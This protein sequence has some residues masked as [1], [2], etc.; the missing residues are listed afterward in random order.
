MST[1]MVAFLLLTK[2]R[3]GTTLEQL[4]MELEWLREVLCHEKGQSLSSQEDCNALVKQAMHYLGKEMIATEKLSMK[5]STWSR[6]PANSAVPV[7]AT[8]GRMKN[9][10]SNGKTWQD[11]NDVETDPKT[12]IEIVYLKPVLKL[13][14]SLQLQYYANTCASQ[15][16][17]ESVL[18]ESVNSL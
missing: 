17:M 18:G 7:A 5:F 8:N 14:N 6:W 13:H 12:H 11:P 4:V 15:F 1:H 3:K 16:S 2:Y 9:R 10:Y